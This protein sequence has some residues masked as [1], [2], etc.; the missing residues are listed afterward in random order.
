MIIERKVNRF[1]IFTISSKNNDIDI[2]AISVYQPH[3]FI[4]EEML[5]ALAYLQMEY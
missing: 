1:D 5:I 3:L 4:S 2:G